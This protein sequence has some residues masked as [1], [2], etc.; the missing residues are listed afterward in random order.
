MIYK[1]TLILIKMVWIL[2]LVVITTIL[3]TASWYSYKYSKGLNLEQA[4][5]AYYAAVVGQVAAF[6]MLTQHYR[7]HKTVTI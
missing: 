1:T 4:D 7:M 6:F 2:V 5:W 3:Y